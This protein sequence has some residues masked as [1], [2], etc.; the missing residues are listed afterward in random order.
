MKIA[1]P[2]QNYDL[3]RFHSIER[4]V[5][6]NGGVCAVNEG[7][8]AKESHPMTSADELYLTSVYLRLSAHALEDSD[9]EMMCAVT[10]LSTPA[11]IPSRV[12]LDTQI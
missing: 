5:N 7:N 10:S 2:R 1:D 9:V 3:K 12:L 4:Y 11:R 8:A 6:H